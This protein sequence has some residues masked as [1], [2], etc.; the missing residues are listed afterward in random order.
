MPKRID[1]DTRAKIVMLQQNGKKISEIAEKFGIGVA[2]VNRIIKDEKERCESDA[3][4]KDPAA[5][6]RDAIAGFTPL[7]QRIVELNAEKKRINGE[8]ANIKATLRNALEIA[9]NGEVPK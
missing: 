9:E 7:Y 6:P 1:A 4:P 3:A 8:L 2:T 5:P